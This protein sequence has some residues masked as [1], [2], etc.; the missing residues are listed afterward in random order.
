M[1]LTLIKRQVWIFGAFLHSDFKVE[2]DL[3][4]QVLPRRGKKK[5]FLNGKVVSFDKKVLMNSH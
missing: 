3:G 5:M 1:T 2:D 4:G